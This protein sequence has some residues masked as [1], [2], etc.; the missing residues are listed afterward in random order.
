MVDLAK[1]LARRDAE[2]TLYADTLLAKLHEAGELEM[3]YEEELAAAALD[4]NKLLCEVAELRAK[5]GILESLLRPIA[6]VTYV[7]YP[8]QQ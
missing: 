4:Y 3:H 7:T 8:D 5:N 2:A 6:P 1:L